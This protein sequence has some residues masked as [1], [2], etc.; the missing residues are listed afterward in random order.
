MFTLIESREE[1]N[2][3]QQDLERSIRRDFKKEIKI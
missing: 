1:I 2:K 3:A